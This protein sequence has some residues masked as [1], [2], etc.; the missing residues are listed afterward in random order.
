MSRSF[1]T[2]AIFPRMPRNLPYSSPAKT[3]KLMELETDSTTKYFTMS[4]RNTSKAMYSTSST[5]P[6]ISN[7]DTTWDASSSQEILYILDS[8]TPSTPPES[9]APTSCNSGM[10]CRKAL[11]TTIINSTA[12]IAKYKMS[13]V[14]SRLCTYGFKLSA[15]CLI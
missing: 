2:L 3:A 12:E 10:S 1:R 9:N 13:R 11:T 5:P 15:L 14:H 6:Y 7:R 8:N 4:S